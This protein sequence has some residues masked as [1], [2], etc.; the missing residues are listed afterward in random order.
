MEWTESAREDLQC[1]S[2]HF[3][4]FELDNTVAWGR[5]VVVEEE[6][7]HFRVESGDPLGRNWCGSFSWIVTKGL[8]RYWMTWTD[9]ETNKRLPMMMTR[10]VVVVAVETVLGLGPPKLPYDVD[11]TRRGD[12]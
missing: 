11:K 10:M 1:P 4:V 3:A 5:V 2:C 8:M 6:Q 12:Q 9:Y 7:L